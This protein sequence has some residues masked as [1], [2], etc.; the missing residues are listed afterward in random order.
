MRRFLASHRALLVAVVLAATTASSAGAASVSPTTFTKNVCAAVAD[1]AKSAKAAARELKT[2]SAAYKASPSPTTAAALRDA[3]TQVLQ[4]VEQGIADT[5]TAA[6][7]SGTPNG[8]EAFVGAMRSALEQAQAVA[9]QLAQ[10]SAAIDVSS[11]ATF[12]AGFEQLQQ[13]LN[14]EKTREKSLKSNPA[15]RHAPRAY[16]RLVVFVTTNADTCPKR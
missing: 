10:H 4:M 16:H 11:S 9:Q 6:E 2:A 7:Q 15:F 1:G 3:L 8:G 13:E 14:D 5:L 12:A